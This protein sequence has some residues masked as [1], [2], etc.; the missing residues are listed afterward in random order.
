[1]RYYNLGSVLRL[2]REAVVI[3]GS[4][5]HLGCGL[6][7]AAAL[8]R[9]GH[10]IRVVHADGSRYTVFPPLEGHIYCFPVRV[11]RGR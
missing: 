3:N 4:V 6:K 5:Q 8:T 9:S 7:K 1:M 11:R 2:L 10:P